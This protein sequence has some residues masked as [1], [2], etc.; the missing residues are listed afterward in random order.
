MPKAFAL[1]A[2]VAMM[3]ASGF[4]APPPPLKLEAAAARAIDMQISNSLLKTGRLDL[5]QS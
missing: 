2:A 3:M 4:S 1:A 5:I